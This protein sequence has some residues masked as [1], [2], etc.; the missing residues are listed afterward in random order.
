MYVYVYTYRRRKLFCI[1]ISVAYPLYPRLN[2]G[3]GLC[4]RRSD[5][6]TCER[7]CVR[8]HP[9]LNWV[10]KGVPDNLCR[11]VSAYRMCIYI[12]IYIQ[13]VCVCICVCIYIYIYIYI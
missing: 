1:E 5:E 9:T 8:A 7:A 10:Y 4:S 6:L 11:I 2:V 3:F 12:Y 13:S